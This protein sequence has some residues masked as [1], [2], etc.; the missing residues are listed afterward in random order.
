ML[1][2][3][4]L[5]VN[6]NNEKKVNRIIQEQRI[7]KRSYQGV[8]TK[9]TPWISSI[10][11]RNVPRKFHNIQ[12]FFTIIPG[13]TLFLPRNACTA[14]FVIYESQH[15]MCCIFLLL[16]FYTLVFIKH[17]FIFICKFVKTLFSNIRQY[18]GF[19]LVCRFI[20]VSAM[21]L[22]SIYLNCI[23][24]IWENSLDLHTYR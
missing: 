2:L 3:K 16:A 18:Y 22:N 21:Y 5:I 23:L 1:V 19:F 24:S 12:E 17:I 13:K 8:N 7:N 10:Y 15:K 9:N 20:V 14:N 6:N 4:R 11:F